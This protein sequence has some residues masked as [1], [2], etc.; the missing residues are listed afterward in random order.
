MKR[1]FGTPLLVEVFT[2]KGYL[3]IWSRCVKQQ[4]ELHT[5]PKE[6]CRFHGN[7]FIRND[8]LPEIM[9]P[10]ALFLLPAEHMH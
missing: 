10:V 6:S 8:V 4:R 9:K 5:Q 2:Q 3:N 1:I 7:L